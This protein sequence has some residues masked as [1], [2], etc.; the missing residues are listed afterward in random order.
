MLKKGR[1]FV[2]AL[3]FALL[4]T[5]TV[6]AQEDPTVTI[7]HTNDVHGRFLP[8][9]T[10]I[11]ICTIATILEETPNAI[12]V[13]AGDT[14][15]GIPFATLNRGMDVVN[16][17]SAAGYS[18]FTPG[19]H[20]FNFG[21]DRLLELRN[22][23]TFDFISSNVYRDGALLLDGVTV[24]E[25]NGLTIGFFG[26]AHP[27]TYYL[28]NPNNIVGI[29][30][31]DPVQSARNAVAE[32]QELEVDLI[33][34]LTHL[35]S[36][37]RSDYRVDGWAITV[38]EEVD[39]IDIIIDGHSH[40]LHTEG[41]LVNGTLVAQAGDHG[42][43]VGRVDIT[44]YDGEIFITAGYISRDYAVENFAPNA[45]IEALVE[46]ILAYQSEI[47]DIVVAYLPQTLYQ[48]EIRSAEM[49]LGNLIADAVLWTSG[50][51]IA[52]T[53]GGGI[54]DILPAGYVTKGDIITV[55][56]FGNY[57]VTVEATPAVL[58]AAMENGVSALPGGGR[59]PQISGFSFTFAPDAEVGERVQSLSIDG[60]EVDKNDTETTFVL[61]INNFMAA[62][63]DDYG[64]FTDL[65]VLLE[66]GNLD[67]VLIAYINYADLENIAVEG[68][69]VAVDA[70]EA[71][72]PTEA[73]ELDQTEE[74]VEAYE[75][76][77]EEPATEE[78]VAEVPAVV[79]P[80]VAGTAVVV[81]CF[82]LN[83]RSAPGMGNNIVGVLR[84]GTVVSILDSSRGWYEIATPYITGWTFGR[85]LEIR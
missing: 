3:V 8:S 72:L 49:P 30:F 83:V 17:M 4:G 41:L 22:A 77:I 56:P 2:L 64:M 9:G 10:A 40:N 43:N 70:P 26:L 66:F 37:A 20:D 71:A 55:L 19:N 18:L 36:G 12:L 7:F 32:L 62:G 27:G 78:P 52:F 21:Q 51:D 44:V 11:G 1:F 15:H 39:G 6:F 76:A 34:A 47:M 63:G 35:G 25:I 58:W 73:E 74:V 28:T 67:E 14:F 75:P 48:A 45:A 61:A 42:R 50:A 16:L 85:Y 79:I 33:V 60:V 69:I 38:A 57:V 24:R 46:E 81:N 80:A 68:R 29:T 54:R 53:N 59:F 13:D 5:A 82:Y 65:D 84:V 23:A 31:A